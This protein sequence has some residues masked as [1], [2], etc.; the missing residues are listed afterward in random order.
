MF[1]A[2]PLP[3]S[4]E[5]PLV[6]LVELLSKQKLNIRWVPTQNWHL[7][8]QFLG[9]VPA[10]K[11]EPI[12]RSLAEV[13]AT[14]SHFSLK[15]ADL[16]FFPPQRP[17]VIVI[18]L[19]A[20]TAHLARFQKEIYQALTAKKLALEEPK[21]L[22]LTL[23]RLKKPVSMPAN[24][25]QGLAQPLLQACPTEDFCRVI[26]YESRLLPQGRLYQEVAS[27]SLA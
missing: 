17:R 15:L 27:F 9:P 16:A 23:G 25:W 10:I 7:T 6:R 2:L 26:L 4:W 8:L 12:K 19:S 18:N 22:H 21:P 20:G 1:V 3:S 5:G 11:I 14:T 24:R 13:T